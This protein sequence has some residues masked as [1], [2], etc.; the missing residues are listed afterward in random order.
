MVHSQVLLVS[1]VEFGALFASQTPFHTLMIF[2]RIAF[3]ATLP[4]A[5]H[6]FGLPSGMSAIGDI[7]Q[8]FTCITVKPYMLFQDT[9]TRSTVDIDDAKHV[10]KLMTS[11]ACA[12]V[13]KITG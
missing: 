7:A 8:S 5:R 9:E 11:I 2:T 12:N 4:P 10:G 13:P 1:K 3:C 6:S